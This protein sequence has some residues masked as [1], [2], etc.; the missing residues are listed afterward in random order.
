[1]GVHLSWVFFPNIALSYLAWFHTLIH[2]LKLAKVLTNTNKIILLASTVVTFYIINT[3]NINDINNNGL[4]IPLV[5][6]HV[7]NN[8]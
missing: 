2:Y 8:S 1:M 6:G 5:I 4:W 7:I 3:K